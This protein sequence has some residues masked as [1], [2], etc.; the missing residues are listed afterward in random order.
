M[1]IKRIRAGMSPLT[2]A[3]ISDSFPVRGEDYEG[4]CSFLA[5]LRALLTPRI[6]VDEPVWMFVRKR[7]ASQL[8]PYTTTGMLRQLISGWETGI[9]KIID[10]YGDEDSKKTFFERLDGRNG[11]CT[12]Y[13]D[14]HEARDLQQ[15]VRTTGGMNARFYID[16]TSKR[17]LVVCEGLSFRSFHLLQALTPRLLPWF[18]VDAPL[19]DD[20][21]ALLQSLTK[22]TSGD[23][24]STL[25]VLASRINIRERAITMMIGGFEKRCRE[26]RVGQTKNKIE[27]M[28]QQLLQA[29]EMY[30]DTL[31]RLNELNDMLT[32]QE[33]ALASISDDSELVDY[34]IH[35]PGITPTH[36]ESNEIHF[37]VK[38]FFELFD[39]E[40]YRTYRDN[41]R[42]FLYA[43]YER[44]DKFESFNA[45]QKFLDAVFSDNP[46][47]KVKMCANYALNLEGYVY[48]TE[49]YPYGQ[50]FEDFIPNPHIHQYACIGDYVPHIQ[51]AIRS[52]DLITAIEQCAASARS[53][54]LAESVTVSY[55]LNDL[56]TS[57]NRIIRLQDGR[58]VTPEEA[59]Q[60]LNDKEAENV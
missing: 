21:N 51:A 56:F 58:D 17:T 18:F 39:P 60:Y 27:Q 59:L 48:A 37:T 41:H 7:D 50:G 40:M 1:F 2:D 32:G 3:S 6:K 8:V 14:C 30:R 44:S 29:E 22:S 11:F 34:F 12:C 54:N 20:E 55:F 25:A 10:I 28:R 19:N 35:H 47:F 5:T 24:E 49:K 16:K 52:G 46:P 9:L 33:L 38:T 13:P 53:I 26:E 31:S 4:D 45:R 57:T 43:G 36:A 23:Y 42:S 15:F